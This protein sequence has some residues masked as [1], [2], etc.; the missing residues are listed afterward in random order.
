ME[1]AQNPAFRRLILL[2]L[3]SRLFLEIVG[4]LSM[5]YFPPASSVYRINDLKYHRP[6]TPLL[7]M[8]T[9][10]DSEW[11]LLIAER[12]YLSHEY[13]KDFGGGR[14]MPQ[15]TVKFFPAYPFA[16][17]I[18]SFLTGNTILAGVLVSS[19]AALI[20]LYYLYKL[21][22]HL[23]NPGTG[24][25]AALLY[26]VYPTA[27]FLSAVYSDAL[28]FAS[29]TAA[30]YYIEQK[31]IL[32]ACIAAALAMLC[33][34]QA[35]LALPVLVWLAWLRFP[36]SRVKSTIAMCVAT[37]LPLAL[38]LFYIQSAFGS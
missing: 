16:I 2:F 35:F 32:P 17:R 10:W 14:Y 15:E 9:H 33:R 23:F 22:E 20:F 29:L 6:Q 28:F 31:K 36:E 13:F 21:G 4:I 24:Y 26:L 19:I 8:W 11:W 30:F 1:E 38:Y 34:S 18:F 25:R 37:V 12:G 5:F 7:E 27:F 3:L